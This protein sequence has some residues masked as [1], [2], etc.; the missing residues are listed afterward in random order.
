MLWIILGHTA[1]FFFMIGF[2]NWRDFWP[3]ENYGSKQAVATYWSM[4]FFVYSAGFAVDTFFFL[5]GFLSALVLY[6]K[7]EK[8]QRVSFPMAVLGRFLRLIPVYAYVIMAFVWV[9]GKMGEGPLW[10]L[11]ENTYKSCASNWWTNLLFINNFHPAVYDNQCMAWTWYLAND[12]QFF[13]IGFFVVLAYKH[14]PAFGMG[15]IALICIGSWV[16]NAVIV[17]SYDLKAFDVGPT[18]SDF[19][20]KIYDKPY[21]RIV[22]YMFGMSTAFV[23]CT[24]GKAKLAVGSMTRAVLIVVALTL[25]GFTA[26]WTKLAVDTIPAVEGAPLIDTWGEGLDVFYVAFSRTMW[27]IGLVIMVIL[28][29]TDQGGFIEKLLSL[30]FWDPVGKLTYSAYLVHPILIRVVYFN[31]VALIRYDGYMYAIHYLGFLVLAYGIATIL[32]CCVESPFGSLVKLL[33][34]RRGGK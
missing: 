34:T 14:K 29:T 6:R 27:S 32:Y 28:C 11:M 20:N 16:A 31:R 17:T 15:L 2:E 30:N 24:Y 13:I 3:N 8:G 19:Q 33:T 12:M 26:S 5:S 1:N 4:H 18:Y 22:P 21:A 7:L 10:Y 23:I 25:F 9:V